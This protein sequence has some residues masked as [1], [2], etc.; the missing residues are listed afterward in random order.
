MQRVVSV[1]LPTWPAD[2]LLRCLGTNRPPPDALVVLVGR[3]ARGRII[4]AASR[5]ALLAGLRPGMSLAHASAIFGQLTHYEFDPAEDAAAL[6]RLAQWALRRYS[7]IVMPDPPA[8]L[9]IDITG[10]SH[11]YGGET[12]LV[13][14]LRQRLLNS[15]IDAHVCVADTWGAAHAVARFSGQGVFCI[16]SGGTPEALGSLPTEALRLDPDLAD[17]L[18]RVGLETIGDLMTT[19]RGPLE[20]RFGPEPGRRLDQAL[21]RRPDLITP[22]QAPERIEVDHHFSDPILTSDILLQEVERLSR[23]LCEALERR[24]LGALEIDLLTN[25]V[26]GEWNALR[27]G[28]SSPTRHPERFMRLLKDRL[29]K[30]DRGFGIER[31]HLSASRSAP[32]IAQQRETLTSSPQVPDIGPLLDVLEAR[33]GKQ[34][35]YRI[36]AVESDCPERSVERVS[37]LEPPNRARWDPRWPRPARLLEPPDP[38]ETIALLPDQPPVQFTWKGVR[39]RVLRADGPERIHGEWIRGQDDWMSVRDYF[40][41]EDET[42]ERYWLFREGDGVSLETGSHRWFL[43][44]IFG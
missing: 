24:S 22:I 16:P 30:T 44:G 37:P 36:Q 26:G 10:A 19:P 27:V 3:D 5:Q 9:V 17:G 4:Q 38:I 35:L 25:A 14:D 41:V 32:L 18:R 28:F 34:R 6:E 43:H 33:T 1:F 21:G 12:D 15:R 23:S 31:L 8:G 13:T 2:R 20:L 42:G 7:P 40:S 39:R 11:L 29:Q